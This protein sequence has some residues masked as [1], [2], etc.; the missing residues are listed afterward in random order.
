MGQKGNN[1]VEYALMLGLV[2]GIGWG[3]LGSY[4]DGIPGIFGSA[5]ELLQAGGKS[6]EDGKPNTEQKVYDR[7]MKWL[8]ETL[9]ALTKKET[10][11][12][13]LSF[14]DYMGGLNGAYFDKRKGPEFTTTN[15]LIDSDSLSK[16]VGQIDSSA[17]QN[18]S[19]AMV[20]LT[21]IRKMESC[22]MRSPF[23]ARIRMAGRHWPSRRWGRRSRRMCIG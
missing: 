7:H 19:W 18:D 11:A 17:L 21:V 14:A 5:A 12:G 10:G 22:T 20:G 8:S 15:G 6:D 2:V 13:F 9:L 23:T 1:F 4:G 3:L 16:F